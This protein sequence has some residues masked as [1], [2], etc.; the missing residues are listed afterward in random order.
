MLQ[1]VGVDFVFYDRFIELCNKKGVSPS[2]AG[3]SIGISKTSVTRWKT[4]GIVPKL[5]T[6]NKLAEYFGVTTDYLLTGTD[7]KK[8]PA[9]AE[10]KDADLEQVILARSTKPIPDDEMRR[11][12]KLID[13]TIDTFLEA[14]YNEQENK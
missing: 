1:Y 3:L 10:D 7:N 4:S 9:D 6:L 5:D 14:Y 8:S 11:I 2:K 12:K 13:S